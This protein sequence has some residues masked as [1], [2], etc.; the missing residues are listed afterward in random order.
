MGVAHSTSKR[1]FRK[2]RRGE[3]IK[4]LVILGMLGIEL[5]PFYMMLQISVKDNTTFFQNPWVPPNSFIPDQ[6]LN[7]EI[8]TSSWRFS[9]Y[10]EAS[11]LILP[12]VANTI[13]VAVLSA[14]GT[15]SLAIMGAYFFARKKMPFS[16]LLWWVFLFLLLMPS[17][18][19]IVPLFSLLT[20]FNLINTLWALII[21]HTAA[22]QAFNI[23]ILR[24]FIEEMPKDLFEAAEIDGASHWQQMTKIVIPLCRPIIGT[25]AIFILINS[26]N[27]YLLPLV[28]MRDQEL[29]TLGVGLIYL[30]GEYVKRWGMIMA[31][32]TLSSIPLIIVFLFTMKL[33]IR[34]LSS[35]AVKG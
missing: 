18:A 29:F 9:N 32:F 4:H 33:F 12:Y 5:L 1:A 31:S 6:S 30:D 17:I 28:I 35:G 10:I 13:F 14:V 21:V 8:D 26:W 25:L 27:E 7:P 3:W 22:G 11:E 20:H 15:L 24:H 2:R 19:S 34:S 16:G 23:F